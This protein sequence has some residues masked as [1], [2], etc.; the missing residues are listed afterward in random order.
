MSCDTILQDEA[1][2]STEVLAIDVPRLRLRTI[3]PTAVASPEP[4]RES[5]DVGADRNPDAAPWIGC[6]DR[7]GVVEIHDSRLLRPGREAFCRALVEAA[8]ERFGAD[9]A[10]MRL[11]SSTCR[12]DFEPGRFD[13][14]ELAARAAGAIRSA[15][16]AVRDGSGRRS[17]WTILTAFPTA[18]DGGA[19]VREWRKDSSHAAM[20]ADHPIDTSK[21]SGRLVDLAMAGGSFVLAIGG[22][23]LPGIPTLPFVIMT[24]RYAIRVSPRIERLLTR[25]P[26]CARAAGGGGDLRWPGVRLGVAGEDDGPRGALRRG[27]PDPP[28]SVAGRPGPGARADGLHGVAGAGPAG[29]ECCRTW[30][31]CVSREGTVA[32]RGD[33]ASWSRSAW[34]LR[35]SPVQNMRSLD[36]KIQILSLDRQI[37][38]KEA[39]DAR[40]VADIREDASLDLAVSGARQER[41]AAQ[42]SVRVADVAGIEL[43]SIV[44]A[45]VQVDLDH[46]AARAERQVTGG[47]HAAPARE[48]VVTLQPDDE[49]ACLV[50]DEVDLPRPCQGASGR[51][52]RTWRPIL[53]IERITVI[54]LDGGDELIPLNRISAR[55]ERRRIPLE[56]ADPVPGVRAVDRHFITVLIS[57]FF[58]EPKIFAHIL[59]GGEARYRP[60]NFSNPLTRN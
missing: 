18:A 53:I 17:G 25:Q 48:D 28:S 56:P 39:D 35:T 54:R 30:V 32:D 55:R 37:F 52:S 59:D 26:W 44:A 8:V 31:C 6:C 7:S 1:G 49:T 33:F 46:V 40:A 13:R 10:E 38:G 60:E 27:D 20:S 9:R 5:A 21:R 12:L 23:I 45:E 42:E 15:T 34:D 51:E 22:V 3:T 57:L 4:H 24:G 29:A 41:V 19:H 11:E 50:D 14:A 16:P 36:E 58:E 2:R 47:T 43:R